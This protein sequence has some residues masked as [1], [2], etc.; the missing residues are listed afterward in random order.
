MIQD[1][2]KAVGTRRIEDYDKYKSIIELANDPN[3]DVS[4]GR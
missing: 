1:G 3:F 4:S 2:G